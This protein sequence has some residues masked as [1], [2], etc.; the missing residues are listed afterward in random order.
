MQRVTS[1]ER[2]QEPCSHPAM[3]GWPTVSSLRRT[4][5][6]PDGHRPPHHRRHDRVDK[7]ATRRVV[8]QTYPHQVVALSLLL[9][10]EYVIHSV[11][12]GTRRELILVQRLDPLL[13]VNTQ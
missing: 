5:C 10:L 9:G 11:L 2:R 4:H 7:Q 3:T 12:D 1:H 8:G 6:E 13:H